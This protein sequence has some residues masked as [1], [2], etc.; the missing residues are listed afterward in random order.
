MSDTAE[1]TYRC[2]CEHDDCDWER[3]ITDD[4]AE[5]AQELSGTAMFAH[6][7]ATEHHETK[8][9][10][11][12]TDGGEEVGQATHRSELPDWHWRVVVYTEERGK[13]ILGAMEPH[14]A[15][16][17]QYVADQLEI[18]VTGWKSTYVPRPSWDCPECGTHE[19]ATKQPNLRGDHDWECLNCGS[20]FWGEPMD[21]DKIVTGSRVPEWRKGKTGKLGDYS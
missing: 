10:R 2:W 7:I 5:R 14:R 16:A 15:A 12:E 17:K 6:G 9:E 1:F 20:K 19:G 3:E 4:D 21:W 13:L 11:I 8:R 18:D